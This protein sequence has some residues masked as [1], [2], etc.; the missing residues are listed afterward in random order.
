MEVLIF[1]VRASANTAAPMAVVGIVGI[2]VALFAKSSPDHVEV[3]CLLENS[4]ACLVRQT[5]PDGAK[6]LQNASICTISTK[7]P[8]L[9]GCFGTPGSQSTGSGATLAVG[10]QTSPHYVHVEFENEIGELMEKVIV[11]SSVVG[12]GGAQQREDK[13]KGAGSEAMVVAASVLGPHE[14]GGVKR[15]LL[16]LSSDL[17]QGVDKKEVASE[18]EVDAKRSKKLSKA[19][20]AGA[21]A[22]D[23]G[24][25]AVALTEMTLEQ[26]LES[27]SASMLVLEESTKLGHERAEGDVALS[28]DSLVTLLDQALQSGDEGLLEQCLACTDPSTIDSTAKKLAVGR[29]IVL[30]RKL[31][32]KF[33]KRPSRGLLV[34]KWLAAVLRHHT[35]FLITVPDLASQL[36]GLSQM[37][38]QRLASYSRMSSL[39]GRLD[40]LMH[41]VASST[42]GGSSQGSSAPQ[43]PRKVIREK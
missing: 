3:I 19:V 32:A 18:G 13:R 41:Q 8:V 14:M 24:S 23:P 16:A 34:T 30:L 35:S 15:P 25:E 4:D 36:A 28:A 22:P 6:G 12:G 31:V 43:Q 39:A 7:G 21:T 29:V 37:L 26:R 42:S 20:G 27:L 40:L 5:R 10:S 2:P 11:D 17:D 1:D 9:S 33:E 38:E